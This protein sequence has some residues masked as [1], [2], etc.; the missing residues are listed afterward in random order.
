MNFDKPEAE[1][2]PGDQRSVDEGALLVGTAFI[3]AI[4][5]GPLNA[6]LTSP[7]GRFGAEMAKHMRKS[8]DS[9]RRTNR[10]LFRQLREAAAIIAAIDAFQRGEKDQLRR[11]VERNGGQLDT[12]RAALFMKDMPRVDDANA[13]TG[14]M[15]AY[16]RHLVEGS[17]KHL[18]A[19]TE[20][21][22]RRE[23]EVK[24]HYESLR[25]FGELREA[26]AYNSDDPL[27]EVRRVLFVIEKTRAPG[28]RVKPGEIEW[29]IKADNGFLGNS[30][31]R[32]R[33]DEFSEFNPKGEGDPERFNRRLWHTAVLKHQI[34]IAPNHRFAYLDHLPEVSELFDDPNALAAY[35]GIEDEWILER[36]IALAPQLLAPRQL[37]VFELRLSGLSYE[38]IAARLDVKQETV[39]VQWFRAVQKLAAAV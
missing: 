29:Q 14:T 31:E 13:D 32:S 5:S 3:K 6:P 23:D 26:F 10:R 18:I 37:E 22:D 15:I 25:K 24:R 19:R 28:E 9:Y 11:W 12:I 30:V 33:K 27:N 20:T 2:H 1:G 35:N 7:L 17:K 38:Q 21:S 39:R 16:A 8:L 4:S 36:L 34:G